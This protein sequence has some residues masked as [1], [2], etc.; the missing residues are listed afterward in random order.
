MILIF[1]DLDLNTLKTYSEFIHE[2]E[3]SPVYTYNFKCKE[4]K[5]TDAGFVFPRP[6]L[7]RL[8][9]TKPELLYACELQ[10]KI[11]DSF[12]IG[13]DIDVEDLLESLGF[14]YKL[15]KVLYRMCTLDMEISK[16]VHGDFRNME[17]NDVAMGSNIILNC[18][19][20]SVSSK[21]KLGIDSSILVALI[22]RSINNNYL[23]PIIR[24]LTENILSSKNKSDIINTLSHFKLNTSEKTCRKGLNNAGD[25]KKP[26]NDSQ[27]VISCV[28]NVDTKLSVGHHTI[29]KPD[30]GYYHGINTVSQQV[31]INVPEENMST[32]RKPI[33]ELKAEFI[34]SSQNQKDAFK[35]FNYNFRHR[36]IQFGRDASFN[37]L[38]YILTPCDKECCGKEKIV[39]PALND[40]SKVKPKGVTQDMS[41]LHQHVLDGSPT[42]AG[43]LFKSFEFLT[44]TYVTEQRP[45]VFIHG[46]QAIYEVFQKT[47][48][49]DIY[50]ELCKLISLHMEIFHTG[51]TMDKAIFTAYMMAL[52]PLLVAIGYITEDQFNY[53]IGCY[54]ANR[55]HQVLLDICIA[56]EASL[57]K[58][59]CLHEDIQEEEMENNMEDVLKQ[60]AEWLKTKSQNNL[61]LQLWL[62][63]TDA[64]SISAACWIAQRAG[65]ME[66]FIHTITSE[67]FLPFFFSW[68]RHKYSHSITEYLR[69]IF[70]ASDYEKFVMKSDCFFLNFNSGR[71]NMSIGETQVSYDKGLCMVS[72]WCMVSVE[73]QKCNKYSE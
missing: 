72:V 31:D 19:L 13:E 41:T 17:F 45:L 1:V 55:S 43:N 57:F 36:S 69:D 70:L 14:A 23:P 5:R 33:T 60:Y 18:F 21:S 51:W 7:K 3:S 47:R 6:N 28:D 71:V 46:D 40:I 12:N 32:K 62:Q 27:P 73:K 44:D 54:N 16:K 56:V 61:Q 67:G 53:L 29:T 59:F 30:C 48:L 66:L 34:Q 63:F 24:S 64:V 20:K 42:D 11:Y 65:S 52:R 68:N 37:K 15:G 2:C 9:S 8:V 38:H 22:H 49:E 39:I 4:I 50:H 25:C 26:F 58:Y 35:L 10:K